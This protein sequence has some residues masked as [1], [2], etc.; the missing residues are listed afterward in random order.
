MTNLERYMLSVVKEESLFLYRSREEKY[1]NGSVEL[2][3]LEYDVKP[4]II[5]FFYS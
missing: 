3:Q 5:D 1:Q 4:A 2:L